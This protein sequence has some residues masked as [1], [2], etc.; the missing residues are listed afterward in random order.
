MGWSSCNAWTT[1]KVV[2]DEILRDIEK[3]GYTL[4]G[5]ASTSQG[6]YFAVISPKNESVILCVMIKKHGKEYSTKN[7][8]EGMGPA[9]NDCP[10]KLL[11]LVEGPKTEY[12]LQWRQGVRAY[13]ASKLAGKSLAKSILQ[14]M[15]I[16]LYDSKFVVLQ[17]NGTHLI[18][19]KDG[20][21]YKITSKQ[22]RSVSIE[23]S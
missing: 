11:D 23:G 6:A 22:F 13:H 16:S 8:D 21:R 20:Q 19:E 4:K 18:A 2:I 17:N 9:M 15:T 1:K 7:M 10:L 12:A 3:S 14:G 5:H